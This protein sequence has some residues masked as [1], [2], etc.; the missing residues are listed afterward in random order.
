M[1]VAMPTSGS[2]AV[3]VAAARISEVRRGD[4]DKTGERGI[5][6]FLRKGTD[7]VRTYSVPVATAGQAAGG[8]PHNAECRF[9]QVFDPEVGSVNGVEV[10]GGN[11]A[12]VA[13]MPNQAQSGPSLFAL[14]EQDTE[15]WQRDKLENERR[16]KADSFSK[17]ERIA[18][19]MGGAQLRTSQTIATPRIMATAPPVRND[20]SGDAVAS[21]SI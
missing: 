2:K 14:A 15:Q 19:T 6:Q 7:V 5:G 4:F 13:P 18:V 10:W 1:K 12:A 9:G 20:V 21:S 3:A 8:G 16:P 11:R 17:R